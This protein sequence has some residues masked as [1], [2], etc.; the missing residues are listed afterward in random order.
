MSLE[1][2]QHLF[3]Q[4][5]AVWCPGESADSEVRLQGFES[6]SQPS[7][8]A[9]YLMKYTQ[10]WAALAFMS[11]K[12]RIHNT[13]YLSKDTVGLNGMACMNTDPFCLIFLSARIID[14]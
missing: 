12:I 4:A 14:P 2:L 11:T 1:L 8:T 6:Q 5:K 9:L 10:P 7:Q 3:S 13:I